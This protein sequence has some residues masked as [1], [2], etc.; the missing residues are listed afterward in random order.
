V[1]VLYWIIFNKGQQPFDIQHTENS[2]VQTSSLKDKP[3]KKIKKE[4]TKEIETAKN[5]T[6]DTID[7][8]SQTDP[9]LTYL[10]AYRDYVYFSKCQIIFNQIEKKQDPV[11]N[12]IE[13]IEKFTPYNWAIPVE[14]QLEVFPE[15]LNVFEV[16]LVKCQSLLLTENES[17]KDAKNRL[18]ITYQSITPET[19]EEI[20]LSD[21]LN[22]FNQYKKLG[23]DL[24]SAYTGKTVLDD[25]TA[26]NIKQKI[27]YLS[28]ESKRLYESGNINTDDDLKQRLDVLKKE[29]N[30]LY[31]QLDKDRIT[32]QDNIIFLQNKLAQSKTNLYGFLKQNTSPDLF[33]AYSRELFYPGFGISSE[34]FN[35][36][37]VHDYAFQ[38]QIYTI[39]IN[40]IACA[41]NYPCNEDSL[42][43]QEICLDYANPEKFACGK[44]LED[45]Y[46]NY[47]LG[48]NQIQDIENYLNYM[49]KHYAKN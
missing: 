29:I 38:L 24:T 26:N 8:L 21:G 6:S 13:R 31:F 43:V 47:L 4:I 1:L 9:D 28:S 23:I 45:Y 40:L 11:A 18:G 33:L 7:R 22:L 34:V 39:G 35:A 36:I 14:T 32:D 37:N 44:N 10:Q 19:Q 25:M 16:Y 49:L 15:Q 2:V 20:D 30:T 3:K 46:F 42:L 5:I 41:M 12:F 17:F 48:P 27:R